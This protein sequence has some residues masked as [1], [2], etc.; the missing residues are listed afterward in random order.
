M[1]LKSTG[2][3]LTFAEAAA[4]WLDQVSTTRAR[5]TYQSRKFTLD[6]FQKVCVVAYPSD[7]TR[8]V[9]MAFI[10]YLGSRGLTNRTIC[11]RLGALHR[12]LK[13]VGVKGMPRQEVNNQAGWVS[14]S[15]RHNFVINS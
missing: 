13:T 3:Q 5:K 9:V 8:E 1:E 12:F 6:E 14:H 7:V 2:R 11:N 4:K 10:K 15:L